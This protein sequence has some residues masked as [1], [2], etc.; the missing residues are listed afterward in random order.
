MYLPI[1]HFT[2][3]NYLSPTISGVSAGNKNVEKSLPTSTHNIVLFSINGPWKPERLIN[4]GSEK[5][6]SMVL[7]LYV[8]VSN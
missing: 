7:F 3:L 4:I 1:V 2:I 6:L 8:S 5:F